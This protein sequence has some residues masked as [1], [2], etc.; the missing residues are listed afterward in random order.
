MQLLPFLQ[1][2][3]CLLLRA[4]DQE[5]YTWKNAV[6]QRDHCVSKISFALKTYVWCI[7]QKRKKDALF[8]GLS[9]CIHYELLDLCHSISAKIHIHTLN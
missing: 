1:L 2:G 6:D 8:P 7:I 5:I 4:R 9:T 3:F